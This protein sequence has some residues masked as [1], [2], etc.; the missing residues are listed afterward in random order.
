MNH[1]NHLNFDEY[2]RLIDLAGLRARQLR[3][4]AIGNFGRDTGS[5]VLRAATRFA[6]SLARHARLRKQMGS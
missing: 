3:R 2:N 4:E 6:H 5:A 1:P